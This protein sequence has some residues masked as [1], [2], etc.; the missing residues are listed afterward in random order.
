MACPSPLV[1]ARYAKDL[2][3]GRDR[4]RVAEHVASCVACAALVEQARTEPTL[5]VSL[6][7]MLE[8]RPRNE[9]THNFD[10]SHLPKATSDPSNADTRAIDPIIGSAEP[11]TNVGPLDPAAGSTGDPAGRSTHSRDSGQTDDPW[12]SDSGPS[13]PIGAVLTRGTPIGR[14]LVIEPLG[15]GGL[16]DVYAAY[17]P[18]LDRCVA[19][20]VLRTPSERTDD[21]DVNQTGSG[22]DRLIRE[23]KALAR[24]SHPNVVTV[25]DAGAYGNDVFIAMERVQGLTLSQ[26]YRAEVRSW[27]EVRDVFVAAGAGL[28]AAHEAGI[29]HRDFKPQNVIVSPDGRPRVLDFGLARA[30]H[31]KPKNEPLVL[32]SREGFATGDFRDS[33]DQS[34]TMDGAVMG[35][36][37]YMAPEQFEGSE[38]TGPEADQF[39]FCAT[40]WVALYRQRPFPGEELPDLVVAVRNGQLTEPSDRRGV[41][42]W[43]HKVMVRGL[44]RQP[45]DRFESIAAL[46]HALQ[47]DKRS[48]RRQWLALGTVAVVSALGAA[49]TAI[50]L[51]PPL[52]QEHRD[53]VSAL[54]E[55]ARDAAARSH[56]VYPAPED[57]ARVTAYRKVLELEALDG[58]A[59][60]LA[61]NKA[62]E[63]RTEMADTLSR[64]GDRYFDR[65]GGRA[66]AADYYAAA[67]IFDPNNEHARHRTTLTPGEIAQLRQQAA[68]GEF[69][70]SELTGAESLAVLALED[71]GEQRRRLKALY[72]ADSPIPPSTSTRLAALLGMED[73]GA[74]A[75]AAPPSATTDSPDDT[76]DETSTTGAPP[77]D[78]ESSTT[79]TTGETDS[80]TDS[81]TGSETDSSTGGET[82]DPTGGSDASPADR[83]NPA[84]AKALARQG[85]SAFRKGEFAQAEALFHRA[86]GYNRR[87]A[88]A[89]GGLSELYFE[90]GSYQKAV[91]YGSKAV[92][93]APRRAR[94]RIVL[95]DAYFKTLA[96]QNARRQYAKAESLGHPSAAGRLEQLRQR[97]GQ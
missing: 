28:Q 96:Y 95:G 11:V 27:Q 1:L 48:R 39:S 44:S 5:G 8:P 80:S 57:E 18:Q 45:G 69:T 87:N 93:A 6:A 14:Y 73:I 24:L 71:E 36:P 17:D 92:R 23:A 65:E 4:Q 2:L 46:L 12:A 20:K 15:S 81:E 53:G 70:V 41:P 13:H 72:H 60:D 21:P 56:Y 43:L 40:M 51:Q 63:L 84:K 64:L 25:H 94:Y 76:L 66:F 49:T 83:R 26:W 90:R 54:A 86:L 42:G 52:T 34:I 22:R 58:P 75:Y 61:E 3:E 67:L 85:T 29:I 78:T 97:L 77:A 55:Q 31:R 74:I 33:L 35:T 59:D 82:D 38:A 37:Q 10:L 91:Q 47:R 19:V 30:V 88:T 68:L 62:T 9:A 7:D 50:A 16:G 89:L 32:A 79:E